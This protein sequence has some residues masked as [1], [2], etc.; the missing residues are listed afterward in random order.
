MAQAGMRLSIY[1]PNRVAREF[2]TN[3]RAV[4][5]R[6]TELIDRMLEALRRTTVADRFTTDEMA[7]L[8]RIDL[9]DLPAFSLFGA[10]ARDVRRMRPGM[11]EL[12]AKLVMLT[13]FEEIA[14][15]EYLQGCCETGE[16]EYI[17]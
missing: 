5:Q 1:L 13:P 12:L 2:R 15:I 3:G 11:D 14:L 4:S 17:G 6:G 16:T 7:L 10:L 8:G 9:D